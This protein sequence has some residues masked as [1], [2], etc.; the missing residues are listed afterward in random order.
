MARYKLVVEYHGCPFVGWQRQK[1]GVSV[2]QVIEEAIFKFSGGNV[3][4]QVAGRTDAGVHATGQVCHFDL[5]KDT[6][7][8]TVCD[9]I[10]FHV[11]PNL[12]FCQNA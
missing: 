6:D 3:I 7:V 10:N 5:A 9:A 8:F 4:T 11:K 2:Q 12:I 1:N